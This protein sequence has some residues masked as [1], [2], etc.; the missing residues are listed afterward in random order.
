VVRL[1][2]ME[3]FGQGPQPSTGLTGDIEVA[4]E[5]YAVAVDV[6]D[7]LAYPVLRS[8]IPVTPNECSVKC[9]VTV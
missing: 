9:S 1:K 5:R 6:E 3:G 7:A 4:Q 8:S 2:A